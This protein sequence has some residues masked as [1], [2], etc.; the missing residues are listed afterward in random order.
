M[1]TTTKKEIKPEITFDDYV[2]LD[3]RVCE[4]L[5]VEKV[6]KADKLY[7]LKIQTGIDERVVVSAIADKFSPEELL[8]KKM[9]FVLNLVPR[10]IRGI[11]SFAMIIMAEG[12]DGKYFELSNAGAEVGSIVI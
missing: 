10:K 6:E 8:G 4:I 11:D 5:S 2:K 1:E 9:P 12:A 7:L 3:V